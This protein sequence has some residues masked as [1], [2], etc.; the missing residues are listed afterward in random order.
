MERE[1][2]VNF[3]NMGSLRENWG[4]FLALGIGLIVLGIAAIGAPFV[5]TLAVETLIAWL[6]VIGGI[7]LTIHA[8]RSRRWGRFAFELIGGLLYV[9][10]GFLMLSYPLRGALTLTLVLA[11]FFLAEGA[12]KIF[13]SLAFRPVSNWGW[14]F[15]SGL[16]SMILGVLLWAGLPGA[17]LVAIGLL[18]GIDLILGGISMVMISLSA[19]TGSLRGTWRCVGNECYSRA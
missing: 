13:Q 14:M 18:V 9:F 19:R 7:V 16:A 12:V 3:I 1:S 17:S 5:A 2:K 8:F 4:W 10:I 6:L 15:F 11:I